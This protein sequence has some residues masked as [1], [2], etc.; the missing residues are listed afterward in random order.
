MEGVISAAPEKITG[1]T[2]QDVE[3]QVDKASACIVV[4]K[5]HRSNYFQGILV[6]I[7]TLTESTI[8]VG[9]H[10]IVN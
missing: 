2:Q 6:I 7:L 10:D 4:L 5:L 8:S 1:C 9:L 3:I